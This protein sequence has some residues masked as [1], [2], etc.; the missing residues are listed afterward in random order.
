LNSQETLKNA[1]IDYIEQNGPSRSRTLRDSFNRP[2]MI[3]VATLRE[4]C[5]RGVL[6]RA[7]AGRTGDPFVYSLALSENKQGVPL[8]APSPSQFAQQGEMTPW[9]A[10]RKIT[11]RL[12]KKHP[13]A[14]W[15]LSQARLIAHQWNQKT[16]IGTLEIKF[17]A[18]ESYE[19]F[20]PFP[21][22]SERLEQI[23]QLLSEELKAPWKLIVRRY[24]KHS[25]KKETSSM[26]EK[27]NN[28]SQETPRLS[29]VPQETYEFYTEHLKLLGE[30]AVSEYQKRGLPYKEI[31]GALFKLLKE[32]EMANVVPTMGY[33]YDVEVQE[34][35]RRKMRTQIIAMT[36]EEVEARIASVDYQINL[37][38]DQWSEPVTSYH[39][40]GIHSR[41]PVA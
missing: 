29:Y 13:A 22:N 1:L 28:N 6:S 36:R 25:S 14:A 35:V 7:G 5:E 26:P 2:D 39:L 10:L 38:E 33:R 40:F 19:V 12:Q 32:L 20:G 27:N 23:N 18:K 30:K 31:Q 17:E 34:T 11:E 4:L 9:K 41:E 3:I 21:E 16:G 24:S 8:A 15:H 37:P